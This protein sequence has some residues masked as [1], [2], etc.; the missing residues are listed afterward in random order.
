MR[1]I[2]PLGRHHCRSSNYWLGLY[3]CGL[4]DYCQDFGRQQ[5]PCRVPL[6][7]GSCHSCRCPLISKVA[8]WTKQFKPEL[9]RTIGK[10]SNGA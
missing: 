1:E 10:A 2:W 5:M 6:S 8:K 9:Q 7:L 4:C 3:T